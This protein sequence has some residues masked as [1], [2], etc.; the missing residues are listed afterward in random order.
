MKNMK[1]YEKFALGLAQQAGRLMRQNFVLHMEK[2]NKPEDGSPL[3]KTDLAINQ[4]VIDEVKKTF[5]GHGVL[6]EEQSDYSESDEFVWVCDPID[7]TIPFSHGLPLATFS[8]ALV[9]SGQP[10]LGVVYDPFLKYCFFAQQGKGAYLNNKPIKVSNV[11]TLASSV[12]FTEYWL[13]APY[14]TLPLI[15][16]LEEVN[17]HAPI[18]KSIARGGVMVAAG[19]AVGVI[20]PGSSSWD[21]AAVKII[22]EEAGGKVTDFYGNEQRYDRKIKGCIAS[23]GIMHAELLSLVEKTVLS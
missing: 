16:A 2:E 11:N 21:F 6:A 15:K 1:S 22:V 17:C 23:N 18:L 10:I 8:L 19:V 14:N 9:Q 3:T 7:G 4:L 20:F 13:Q 5:S 12:V